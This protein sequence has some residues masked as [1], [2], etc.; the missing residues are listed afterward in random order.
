M[1]SENDPGNALSG[2][3]RDGFRKGPRTLVL[4]FLVLAVGIGAAGYFYYHAYKKHIT[5][6]IKNQL[7]AVADLKVGQIV[8]WRNERLAD[9]EFLR[10]NPAV[11]SDIRQLRA[12]PHS[13]VLRKKIT[14][15]MASLRLHYDFQAVVLLTPEGGVL[16]SSGEE[17]SKVGSSAVRAAADAVKARGV[18]MTDLH[19]SDI[20]GNI[21]ID[22]MVPLLF[23]RAGRLVPEAVLMLQ[24][25]PSRFF[26][27]LIQSWP[28]PSA[29]AET[30]L[31][32]Q[33]GDSV[34]YLNELRHR[35]HT[36]LSLAF[37][38]AEKGLTAAAAVLGRRGVIEGIDYRGER[39]LSAVRPVPG[40]PW[41]LLAKMDEN[42]VYAPLREQARLVYILVFFMISA[43]GAGT[44][45]MWR[46]RDADFF[47]RQYEAEHERQLL[48]KR[49]EVL[50]RFANDI[51]LLIDEAGQIVDANEQAV[52]AYG[53][54]RDEL[55]GLS[56]KE[57]RAPDAAGDSEE[58]IRKVRDQK[59]LIYET[60]HRRK[61]GTQF[62]VEVSE[63]LVAVNETVYFESIIRDITE[64]KESE[65]RLIH[66]NRLYAVLSQINQVIVRVSDRDS[67][68]RQIC[69]I[70]VEYGSFTTA[71][72]GLADRETGE[73]APVA[74]HGS[75]EDYL[76]MLKITSGD[77]TYG[78]GPVGIAIREERHYV[79][80]DVAKDPCMLPW[81]S[82][83]LK[84][85][86]RSL[87]A[88]P[89]RLGEA[90]IGAFAVY[91]P[92]TGFFSESEIKLLLEV[93]DDI[94]YALQNI[95]RE[96]VR[97]KTEDTNRFFAMIIQSIPEA[98]C[99]I[100]LD[101]NISSWN[102]GA[103]KML[104]YRETDIIGRPI[105]T[106]IP[107]EIA[108]GE[109]DH[110]MGM[111]STRGFFSGY[112]SVRVAKDGRRVPVEIT[113][114]ALRNPDGK[115]TDF[116]SIMYDISDRKRLE[117]QLL[118]AQK[119][120]AIGQLA[121]GIAHD[122]NNIL[123]AII[124]Y[125]NLIT[126]KMRPDD[127]LRI[128]A[129]QILQAGERAANLT[130][131][132][133]AF[134]R[135]QIINPRPVDIN[136]VIRRVEKLLLRLIGEDVEMRTALAPGEIQVM[137]DSGQIEQ[138]L[139]NL[140]T[141]ARDAMPEGGILTIGS[142]LLEMDDDFIR[143]HGYGR[144]GPYALV[145]VTDTGTGMNEEI[146]RRIF[147]PFFTTKEM[148]RG[149]GLGLSMV[150][151]IVTQHNGYI[152]C[153]SEQGKGTSFALY[154]PLLQA[155]PADVCPDAPA[156]HVSTGGS[157]TVLLAEDD[158][159]LRRLTATVLAEFGYT[160]IEAVDGQDA[161]EKFA[162]HK[163]AVSLLMLDLIMPK[164]GGREVY[165]ETRKMRPDVK[166]LFM[167]GYSLDSAD[168]AE[169][170]KETP[171]AAFILKPVSPRDL[172]IKVRRVLDG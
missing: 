39:V 73:V 142:A 171:E 66:A 114:V 95:E 82:E 86:F 140:A 44:G 48:L 100:D 56:R 21:H 122:F 146:R 50:S 155:G 94:S 52:L 121:G 172:L 167:S 111:L 22:I 59:G 32:Q 152:E 27:P 25:D 13:A 161:V 49:Y 129:E 23:P 76:Q 163:D 147:E 84:R 92:E 144:P 162:E 31:I 83:A 150:Y 159:A 151:G 107:G 54:G 164:K 90:T 81:R 6:E 69:R 5:E 128:H 135:K 71:W 119:M 123:T 15:V 109:L 134:S 12:N 166:A 113:A 102:A 168:G 70:V 93:S 165:R 18:V 115:I 120:E 148:G 131:S 137:A 19:R 24:V 108:R 127:P 42:E 87:A 35:K 117:E 105:A 2:S 46:K 67:L 57:I 65:K 136:D 41:I 40:T 53:Y 43:A 149:T 34:L 74:F 116:A 141:N 139:M 14:D 47:R 99:S 58:I 97:R 130:H 75:G 29:T 80:N 89:V 125:G 9:A 17:R 112:E 158:F 4:V 104:G 68:F 1:R 10:E 153:C 132:L 124:G 7:S 30:V 61:D 138:V 38:L 157:E 96:K 143:T 169:M 55:L 154:L 118:Q 77:E 63:R 88:F 106:V 133:L 91:Y 37:P 145:S 98:V 85:G 103:E 51:I 72:I 64:R 20:T 33:E 28:T 170:M 160:V 11:I 3:G 16:L 26:F 36:A 110:C 45:Y 156:T 126:M 101:G 8:A 79:C 62:P 78:R 60:A